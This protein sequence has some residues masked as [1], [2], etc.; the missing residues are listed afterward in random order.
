MAL[1]YDQHKAAIDTAY[2]IR[3]PIDWLRQDDHVIYGHR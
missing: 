3:R 1:T 2:P